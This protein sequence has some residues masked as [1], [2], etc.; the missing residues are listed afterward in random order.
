MFHERE[1]DGDCT[2]LSN[3]SALQQ[4]H[5]L[6]DTLSLAQSASFAFQFQT[7]GIVRYRIAAVEKSRTVLGVIA[8]IL[9]T[10]L[11]QSQS[12]HQTVTT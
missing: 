11:L 2:E 12:F 8:A 6:M 7:S 5:R 4:V 9:H 1:R 10:R 3:H